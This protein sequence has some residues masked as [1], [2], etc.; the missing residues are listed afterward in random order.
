MQAGQRLPG[1]ALRLLAVLGVLLMLLGTSLALAADGDQDAEPGSAGPASS[2]ASIGDE[3]PALRTATSETFELP[4]GAR[5]TRLY[6]AP[7]NYRDEDGKWKPIE[8]GLEGKDGS[9][10]SN[11]DNS[12]DLALP[13][14]LGAG[15]V[16]LTNDGAWVASRLLGA[17]SAPVDLEGENTATYQ[18]ANPQ[19]S[20]ELSSL[21]TGVKEEIEIASPSAPSTFHFE[22]TAS[23][24]VTPSTANDGAIE[25]RD[26]GDD[27]VAR[28]PAPFMYDSSGAPDGFSNA[29]EYQLEPTDSGAWR[30]TVEASREW[31]EAPGRDWPVTLDPSILG[32][33]PAYFDC[34]IYSAPTIETWNKCAQNGVPTLAAE[35]YNRASTPDEYSRSLT[36]F[37]L[38]GAIAPTADVIGAEMHLYS[39]EAAQSTNGVELSRLTVPWSSYVSWKYSGYPNCYTCQPWATPGGTGSE[40][41]GEVTTASRGGSGPGWWNIPLQEKMVQEWVT[42]GEPVNFGVAVKQLGEKIH[43]CTPTC[44]Y[45]K[46]IFQSSAAS[47]S[48]LRPYL[49][50]TYYPQAPATSKVIAPSDGT[51]T[52]KRLKLQATWN[53]GVTGVTWQYREGKAGLFKDVPVGL[54]RSGEGK[55]VTKWPVVAPESKTSDPLYLDASQLSATLRKKGGSVQIRALFEGGAPG[56]SA[57]V[58]AK[59]DPAL[60]G[61]NDA[62]AGI[63]PGTV[64]LLTG[65]FT[66]TKTDVS[67]PTFN[68]SLDF[69]RTFS[70]RDAGKFGD[71]GVLGQGW[72]PGVP[73]EE[74]G[75][76]EWGSVKFSE[77][78]ETIEGETYKFAW[79]EVIGI[80][81][82][83]IPFEKE[84]GGPNYITPDELSGW[85][86]T[87]P[88]STN[89]FVLLTP[90]GTKTTFDN[91][92][93]PNPNEYLP[94]EVSQTGG[95][96]NST[97]MTYEVV[98]GNRRLKYIIAPSAPG[99]DCVTKPIETA[100]CRML[101]FYYA[102]AGT[103]GASAGLG[104][105][106]SFVTYHAPGYPQP[107][108]AEYKYDT[109]TGRLK[110]VW[111][112][113]I[114][115]AL[116]ET[117]T[118]ESTGQIK[119]ITP[120][121]LKPWAMDYGTLNEEAV[122][123]RLMSVKRDS[124]VAGEA[125]TTIVYGVPLSGSGLPSMTGTN[126]A[127]WG[128]TDMP[129]D[130]TAILPPD[131]E[132]SSYSRASIY[133]MDSDGFAVNAATPAG[134]GTTKPSISTSETDK[135]GNVVRELT[136]QNRIRALDDP[137]GETVPRSK[138][139]A[140]I[141]VFEDEGTE[142]VEERGPLHD[143][144]LEGTGEI[145]PAR[146]YSYVE[147]DQ[148]YTPGS[149]PAPHLPTTEKTA[150]LHEGVLKDIQTNKTEYNWTLRKRTKT[151][152]DAGEGGLKIASVTAYDKDTGLPTE[153]RQPSNEAGG[154]PGTT[155]TTYYTKEGGNGC[156]ASELYA[157]LP[158][159]TG[160]AAQITG[161]NPKLVET[162]FPSYNQYGQPLE[163]TQRPGGEGAIRK[164]SF[165]YDAAGR[166]TSR[167]VEGGGTAVPKVIYA[168]NS[169]TGLPAWQ[170][171]Y[172]EPTP[173]ADNQ[174]I[175]T[176]YDK[177]GQP[178]E[179]VDADENVSTMTYDLLGRPVTTDDGKETQ[180][181]TYDPTSGLLTKL[182]DSA[183]GTFTASYDADGSMVAEGLPNGLVAESTYDEAG[184][185][186]AL[187]YNKTGCS[188]NCTW[189]D[190]G[191][192]RSINGQILSQKS[193]KSRQEY[194]YDKAG[195]LIQANDWNAASGG[196][197]TTRQYKFDGATEAEKLAGKNSN[198]NK[199]V[200]RSSGLPGAC[201]TSGGTEQSYKYDAADRLVNEGIVYDD[202]GRITN[203]PASLA[204][205]KALTTSYFSTDMVASQAQNGITNTF[206]LDAA[207]RQRQRTQ[208]GGLEGVEVFHYASGSD[209]PAW[210]QLGAKWSRNIG[211]IGGGVSAIQDSS[212]GTLL[213]LS[214]LHGDVVATATLSP[215]ATKPVATFEQDE[216]GV[217]K[218]G[219]TQQF[220][221]LGSQGRRT[222]FPSGVIQMGARSYVPTLGRFLTPD[223][224]F[225]GSANAYDY[226]N[227]DPVNNFDLGGEECESPNSAWVKKC[228]KINARMARAE[229]KARRALRTLRKLVRQAR[230]ERREKLSIGLPDIG[231]PTTIGDFLSE[232]ADAIHD[233]DEAT[234]CTIGGGSATGSGEML[235]TAAPK[236]FG[237]TSRIAIA[238]GKV[239]RTMTGWGA[240]TGLAGLWGVC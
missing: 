174:K 144:R 186:T 156:V 56:Y 43:S 191:A 153:V 206:Q 2:A 27:L 58:E 185:L 59:L 182:E 240:A 180:T 110:E 108:V 215:S 184:Q 16:R 55:A 26:Q 50:I 226:A 83:K 220:G 201:A 120:P 222:E 211:G 188:E 232:A 207:L 236:I 85:S 229:A 78:S 192:E 235:K 99:I 139:L 20:I 122:S 129:V 4:S 224:V 32:P 158:C 98:G 223:P 25:F 126:V 238:A 146:A 87:K 23:A 96:T 47:N 33:H 82:E 103:W 77:E 164:A 64:D 228:K 54:V 127:E 119:T 197:C 138:E 148:G 44:L 52:A 213:Q 10:L 5:E 100:G 168:Y 239:G 72:K 203:L 79:A 6:Q 68:S 157:G 35:A 176:Y 166:Y 70:S 65:N 117:Y 94:V 3:M 34:T 114:S 51:R 225:G 31:L 155:K 218:L 104:A 221:W 151:I 42:G 169:T 217:P 130:A 69:S 38:I 205:G 88:P 41:V 167:Q 179:Y 150:A 194:S 24:G 14:R 214:N 165:T 105:R 106:L 91:N 90:D 181:R 109:T 231:V 29:V 101:I 111:D 193:L 195:R 61:P 39:A 18:L 76:G 208:G 46:L 161:A 143:V 49:G 137:K 7:V 183:A 230:A 216:F 173:C 177:L 160:P 187:T 123:G 163:T 198:R 233:V 199:L 118:Y 11:G 140:T 80:E 145:V 28:L 22:L 13:A 175:S 190:F 132:P 75:A 97:R 57:P 116:K 53:S 178:I 48:S 1:K 136:P 89:Q 21:P 133:Y 9:A 227:Q 113:R 93:S 152:I 40:V 62:T 210:T 162:K 154:G 112:P 15:P 67:I 219:G 141:R 63:G 170:S 200:T 212:S 74:N 124:L 135:Y 73:I 149:A 115:P 60:G 19:T 142:M 172:C 30:L 159:M 209:T 128:Q 125:Q 237:T 196:V 66:V 12:F 45:R 147:Y 107:V 81:G 37:R 36:F 171:F 234:S 131:S 189:L 92:G 102:S 121:G 84:E 8:E 204:G 17:P 134:G 71:T 95:P 86:L 202:F